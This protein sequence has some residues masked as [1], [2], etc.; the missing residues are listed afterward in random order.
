MAQLSMFAGVDGAD[1]AFQ[2]VQLAQ[3]AAPIWIPQPGDN[4]MSQDTGYGGNGC[5]CRYGSDDRRYR[6]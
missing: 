6:Q 3:Q 2:I 5:K 1:P 4:G